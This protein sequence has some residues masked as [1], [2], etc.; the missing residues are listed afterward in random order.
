MYVENRFIYIFAFV[1]ENYI[2][3]FSDFNVLIRFCL[4]M[5]CIQ[6]CNPV[7][8]NSVIGII[9]KNQK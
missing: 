6:N 1:V 4:R 5:Y 7:K 3:A 8:N 9:R 2:V